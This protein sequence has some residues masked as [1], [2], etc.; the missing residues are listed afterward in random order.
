[1]KIFDNVTTGSVAIGSIAN[2]VNAICEG[3]TNTSQISPTGGI[4]FGY[5]LDAMNFSWQVTPLY[6]TN[7]LYP[8]R[9]AIIY[10]FHNNVSIS[11][12]AGNDQNK[13]ANLPASY[14]DDFV[15]KVGGSNINGQI[16]S[17]GP[18][19]GSTYGNSLD[20]IAPGTTSNLIQSLVHYNN[21]GYSSFGYTSGACPHATGVASLL[22]SYIKN[23]TVNVPNQLASED[24]ERV[25]EK[26]ATDK[27]IVNPIDPYDDVTGWG[28][29]NAGDAL[30]GIKLPDYSVKHYFANF[31]YSSAVLFQQNVNINLTEGVNTNINPNSAINVPAQTYTGDIYKISVPVNIT[32]TS[33][34]GTLDVWP[35]NSLSSLYGEL[36]NVNDLGAGEAMPCE[37]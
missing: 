11:V 6:R 14:R 29:L 9:D 28:L 3:A 25:I 36:T 20:F 22:I 27:N 31:K 17:N 7:Q 2:T 30:N 5:G 18:G 8:L 19:Q 13:T 24:I 12:S 21:N 26:T 33:G 35:L 1:M 23:N 32:Q 16:Y 15:M 4:V 10:A 37:A 34:R